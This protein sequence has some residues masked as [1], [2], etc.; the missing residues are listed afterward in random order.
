MVTNQTLTYLQLFHC[1]TILGISAFTGMLPET[2]HFCTFEDSSEFTV[3]MRGKQEFR[4]PV[5]VESL[6]TAI[7]WPHEATEQLEV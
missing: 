7:H 5:C 2:G 4:C 3:T 6:R 1:S